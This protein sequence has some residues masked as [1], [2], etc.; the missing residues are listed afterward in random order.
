MMTLRQIRYFVAVAEAGSVSAAGGAI[1]ISQSAITEAIK[2]LEG[3]TGATLFERHAKGVLLT[4][5]GHQFLRHA[6]SI[7]AAVA[8]AHRSVEAGP[9]AVTGTV[10]VGVTN[11]VAGYFLADLLARFRRVFPTVSIE[12][13]ED[14]RPFIEHLLVNGE[15]DLAIMLIS[16]L[17]DR[18]AI[19]T[20]II[21]RS[22]CRLWLAPNHKLAAA[23]RVALADV[24]PEPLIMLTVDEVAATAR[25]WWQSAN[26]RPHVLLNTASVEAVRSLVATGA[27]VAILPDMAFRPWSLEGDRLEAREISDPLPTID[28]GLAWR[29]GSPLSPPTLTFVDIAREHAKARTR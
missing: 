14:E 23:E 21:V 27:G 15:L 5:Q 19:E 17:E 29:R 28:V 9:R 1:G 26:L 10:N 3:E 24:A 13:F 8:D 20:E 12:V 7:L 2:T 11:M 18:E 4:Y 22:Q 16:N 25:S 6:R